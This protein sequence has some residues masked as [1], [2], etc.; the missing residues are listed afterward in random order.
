VTDASLLNLGSTEYANL[1]FLVHDLFWKCVRGAIKRD[2]VCGA[3]LDLLPL[4][5]DMVRRK[6][7]D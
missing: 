6:L 3:V 1:K 4:H 5:G 7:T 2:L